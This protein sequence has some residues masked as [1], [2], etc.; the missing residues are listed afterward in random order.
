MKCTLIL[1]AAM[2]GCYLLRKQA[3]AGRRLVWLAGLSATPE[4]QRHFRLNA[5][6]HAYSIVIYANVKPEMH[7]F[8]RML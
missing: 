6:S 5:L 8:Y 3:A 1:L 7:N 4:K 2:L